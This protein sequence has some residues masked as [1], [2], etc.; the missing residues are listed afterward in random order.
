MVLIFL[1]PALLL[2]AAYAAYNWAYL[3]FAGMA[4][5]CSLLLAAGIGLSEV[6]AFASVMVVGGVAGFVRRRLAM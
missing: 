6:V 3:A 4:L 1:L 5:F 2:G